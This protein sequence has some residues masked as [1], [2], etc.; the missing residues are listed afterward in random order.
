MSIVPALQAYP[1][2]AMACALTLGLLVGS[3]LNVV[4]FRLPKM[5]ERDW[6]NQCRD[7]LANDTDIAKLPEQNEK[8]ESFNLMVPRSR[9]PS[10]GHQIRAW[11]NIP[12]ISYLVLGGKCSQCKAHISLRYPSIELVTGILSV[13][14]VAY[15]GVS[16]NGLAALVLSWS[17]IALTMID[18]DTYLLPDDITL[19]L[20]WL[21]LI[22]NSGGMFTDLSSAVWGAVAGYMSLWLVYQGFKLVTGKEGMGFGDFKLLA[23]LGAWMGWQMLPQIIL[24]SSL[25]GAILGV[26]MMVI[27]GRD[28]N[29]PIPFGPYLAI[30]GWIAFIWGDTINQTYLKLFVAP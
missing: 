25:V 6:Q 1:L 20:L 7:F 22:L 21:G 3:F 23:A 14:V 18:I 27:R 11:E 17:L 9:C 13:I 29:I 16:W 5:M 28:K 8:Q 2:L 12:V 10:C 19:P 4:I 26:A 15:F 24:L 30:A